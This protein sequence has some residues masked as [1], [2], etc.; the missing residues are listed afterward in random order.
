MA[1]ESYDTNHVRVEVNPKNGK[2]IE[3][4]RRPSRTSMLSCNL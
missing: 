4:R 1:L 3:R 2:T